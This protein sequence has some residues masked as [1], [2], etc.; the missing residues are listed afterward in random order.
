MKILVVDDHEP[1]RR[2]IKTIL[3]QAGFSDSEEAVDGKDAIAKLKEKKFDVVL[4][5]Q[6]MPG[7]TGI[8]VLKIIKQD[9]ELK[10]I[11]VIMVTAETSKEKVMEAIQLGVSDYIVKPFTAEILKKKIESVVNKK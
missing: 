8:E 6:N 2:I 7:L 1:M 11:P 10:N 3:R 4:L 5:D 9:P